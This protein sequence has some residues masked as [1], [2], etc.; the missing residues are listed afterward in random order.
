[1]CRLFT[2]KNSTW[3]KDL[4]LIKKELKKKTKSPSLTYSLTLKDQAIISE[5]KAF[6][7]KHNVNNITRTMAYLKFYQ[8]NQEIHWSFLAHMVSR[9]AGWNMTDLKG[10]F[11]PRLLSNRERYS[12]FEFIERGNWLI[13]Q[14]AFPQL[15]LYEKSKQSGQ[16][17]FYL[18]S[19]FNVSLFMEVIWNRYLQDRNP[20]ILTVALIINEQNYIESRVIEKNI[21]KD[22]V[23]NT[24]EFKIQD[25][26]SMNHILFPISNTTKAKL[27]GQTVHHFD[28]LSERIL[29]GKRL[30]LILFSKENLPGI[31][32]WANNTVHTGSRKDYW[33]H[34]YNN[35]AEMAPSNGLK[36]RLNDCNLT[37]GAPRIY[38]PDLSLAWKDQQ[39][40]PVITGDW[41][42]SWN[43][44]QYLMNNEEQ[45]NGDI[46]DDNC[47]T[48]EI[49]EMVAISKKL[50]NYFDKE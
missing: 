20:F 19:Y 1:M 27:V 21:F 6:T 50:I 25:L 5:I 26:L 36:P 29:L 42:K 17:L 12:F 8:R 35:I 3:T 45:P 33:P 30:Y 14:D 40:E 15:L 48:I 16:N 43:V 37:H 44:I 24:F 22:E 41:Y 4:I 32:K 31:E 18:L 11:L 38:S 34:L 49:L 13:F 10:E 2:N 7:D 39:H 23:L 28:S 9:N 46:E 47:K